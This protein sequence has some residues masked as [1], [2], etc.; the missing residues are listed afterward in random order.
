MTH[1]DGSLLFTIAKT[2]DTPAIDVY[3]ISVGAS[4]SALVRIDGTYEKLDGYNGIMK[5]QDGG[6]VTG[7]DNGALVSIA[8]I[9]FNLLGFET[10][11]GFSAWLNSIKG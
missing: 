6:V 3:G 5:Y 9:M 11:S 7:A 4:T 2:G 10:V 1:K 8:G